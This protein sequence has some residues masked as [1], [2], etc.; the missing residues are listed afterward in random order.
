M[1]WR[2]KYRLIAGIVAIVI[3]TLAITRD[4]ASNFF[5]I[6][7]GLG[8]VNIGLFIRDFLVYKKK[9]EDSSNNIEI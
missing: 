1:H 3:S 9:Q 8:L 6:L 5:Y 2:S 7:I 4:N